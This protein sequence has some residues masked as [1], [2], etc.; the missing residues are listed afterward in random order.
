MKIWAHRG[1]LIPNL[2]GNTLADFQGVYKLGVHGIETDVCFT[3]P[4]ET[5]SQEPIIYH[6]DPKN[7]GNPKVKILCLDNF[8]AFLKA[9]PTLFCFLEPKENNEKLT[10]IIVQKITE[11]SLENRAYLT[12]CQLRIPFLELEASPKLL[13]RA[14]VQ[15]PKIKIHLIATFP[16]SLPALV[17]KYNPSIISI[18][19]LPDSKLSVWFFKT[20]LVKMVNL[21]QQII[22]VQSMG[23]EIF[24]GIV[25][26]RKDFEYLASLG[27]NGIMTDDS[28]A[29][30]EFVKDRHAL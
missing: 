22:Q 19:W 15:N 24:G 16:F 25:N 28:I 30:M 11:Y 2:R 5:G 18:G 7:R 26:D 14:R 20:F 13:L 4:D 21:K 12:I 6:P 29:A 3:T 9:R 1:R 27:V 23:I 17:R 8:L 10:D